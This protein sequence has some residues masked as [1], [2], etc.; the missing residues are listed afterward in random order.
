MNNKSPIDISEVEFLVDSSK[1]RS[2]SVID[3]TTKFE[4]KFNK[5]V[6]KK[7]VEQAI[8]IQE[9]KKIDLGIIS[10]FMSGF[11]I[12]FVYVTI[13]LN[14]FNT[15]F[16]KLESEKFEALHLARNFY[17][18][19]LSNGEISDTTFSSEMINI[20]DNAKDIY[21][22]I[23]S[24]L[25]VNIYVALG[26]FVIFLVIIL[27]IISVIHQKNTNRKNSL[28]ILRTLLINCE[29]F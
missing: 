24:V 28:M 5:K 21:N 29:D 18:D 20:D 27:F 25:G 11:S 23:Q 7:T 15:T 19:K 4:E 3:L 2:Q 12:L 8:Y 9:D 13:I 26:S 14:S 6:N 22:D 10:F 17:F 16:D 1:N